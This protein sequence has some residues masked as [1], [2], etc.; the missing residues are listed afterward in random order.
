MP[1]SISVPSKAESDPI[2]SRRTFESGDAEATADT[3]SRASPLNK[4]TFTVTWRRCRTVAGALLGAQHDALPTEGSRDHSHLSERESDVPVASTLPGGQ[5]VSLSAVFS[6]ASSTAS[7]LANT[8]GGSADLSKETTQ[9]GDTV[10]PLSGERRCQLRENQER[11]VFGNVVRIAGGG[12]SGVC[13]AGALFASACSERARA[14][15]RKRS[16]KSVGAVGVVLVST[17]VRPH[18]MSH[19]GIAS[20]PSA[21]PMSLRRRRMPGTRESR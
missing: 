21:S 7:V 19:D 15:Q 20:Q 12:S 5:P 14:R 13:R 9:R 16:F 3:P 1:F 4:E 17:P 10:E 18:S 6:F 11:L 8:G 2:S